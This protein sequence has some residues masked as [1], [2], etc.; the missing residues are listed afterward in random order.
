MRQSGFVIEHNSG[1]DVRLIQAVLV[2]ASASVSVL[3]CPIRD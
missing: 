3:N 1:S 2:V